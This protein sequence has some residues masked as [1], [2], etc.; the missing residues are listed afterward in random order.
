MSE[1]DVDVRKAWDDMN[2]MPGKKVIAI[3]VVREISMALAPHDIVHVPYAHHEAHI[4][5]SNVLQETTVIHKN[6]KHTKQNKIIHSFT[7]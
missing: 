6:N 4:S 7:D 2:Q 3:N 1:L 5:L